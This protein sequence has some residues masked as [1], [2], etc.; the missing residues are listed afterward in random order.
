VRVKSTLAGLIVAT[1]AGV[2]LIIG[3][4]PVE[5][6]PGHDGVPSVDDHTALLDARERARIAEYH[7][8][9]LAA[10]DIDYRVLSTDAGGDLE[11]AAHDY[12]A[13]ARVGSASASGR[14][15]LLVVDAANDRVRLEVSTALEG[16]YTDAFVAYVQNRQMAPFFAAG[17]V[18]DGILATTELIVGRA[19]QARADQAFAPPMSAASL[20]GGASAAAAVGAAS[21]PSEEYKRQTQRVDAAGLDPLQAVETY[22]ERMAR[23]DARSDLAL[24]SSDTIAMLRNRVVTPAQMDNVAKTYDGCTV[25]GVRIRGDAAVVRYRVDERR[26]APYFLRREDDAWRLDLATSSSAIRFNHDNQWRFQ[27]PLPADYG[28]AFEDWRLDGNGFP[29]ARSGREQP[30]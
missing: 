19:Q 10:H 8:A 15:L 2:L 28:F 18:A 25:D 9:L 3:C 13:Q 11:R 4:E 22:H 1:T 29:H 6:L 17:R 20:G 12:F 23:R 26:C 21:E 7:A 14:G 30:P 24:Y 16:V 27:R 5:K